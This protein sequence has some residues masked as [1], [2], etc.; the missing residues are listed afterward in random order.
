MKNKNISEQQIEKKLVEK[1]K[2]V[3]GMALK[4]VS[5]GNSGVPDRLVL[6]AIGK[7]AFVEVKAPGEKPRPLQE[8]ETPSS[9]SS[10]ISPS[11]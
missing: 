2:Q 10:A 9:I 5:P 8:Q 7:I 1:V 3:G 11:R 4:F 6:I